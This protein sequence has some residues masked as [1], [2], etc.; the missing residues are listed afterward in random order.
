MLIFLLPDKTEAL[1]AD[2]F[3][4]LDEQL[5]T[6]T[7]QELFPL[8]LTDNRTEFQNPERLEYSPF[9]EKR[10]GIYYCNP[11]S[12][13]QKGYVGEKSRIYKAGYT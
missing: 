1:V 10:T 12:S 7:F 9:G 5:G 3:D 4:R 8:I 13:W 11:H 2:I 6:D